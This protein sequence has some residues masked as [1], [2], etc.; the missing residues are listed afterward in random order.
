VVAE[1]EVGIEFDGLSFRDLDGGVGDGGSWCC[2][3]VEDGEDGVGGDVTCGDGIG[4]EGL[5]VGGGW[6]GHV[7]DVRM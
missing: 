5:G 6:G 4:G 7:E 1:E 2:S 3:I